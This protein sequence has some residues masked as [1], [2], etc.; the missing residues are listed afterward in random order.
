M[1][2]TTRANRADAEIVSFLATLQGRLVD[3]LMDDTTSNSQSV[4]KVRS[5]PAALGVELP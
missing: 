4:R 2:V 3:F 1:P 5:S